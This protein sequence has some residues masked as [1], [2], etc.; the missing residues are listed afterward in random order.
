[1][2]RRKGRGE[3]ARDAFLGAPLARLFF[4][5]LQMQSGARFAGLRDSAM[6]DD[7]RFGMRVV[8]GMT[9]SVTLQQICTRKGLGTHLT[10][11]WFL[12]RVH[13]D[14]AAQMVQ[15]GVGFVAFPAAVESSV[16]WLHASSRTAIAIHA[17]FMLQLS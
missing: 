4:F 17:I 5:A 13:A 11:I 1:M 8:L 14:M 15:A 2:V 12:L 16:G 7:G 3:V 9:E 10:L 6:L